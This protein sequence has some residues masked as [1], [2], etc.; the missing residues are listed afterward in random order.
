MPLAIARIVKL[1]SGGV[2]PSGL[3]TG[4]RR[5]TPNANP[6]VENIRFIGEPDSPSLSD[7]ETIVRDRI[8]QQ[9]IR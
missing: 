9:T 8:G 3:H 5:L 6:E 2:A 1:K 4:R 7:L